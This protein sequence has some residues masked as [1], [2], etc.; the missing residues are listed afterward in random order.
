MVYQLLL[1]LIIFAIDIRMFGTQSCSLKLR[2]D[3]I[4]T[5]TKKRKLKQWKVPIKTVQKA[6]S[7][8]IFLGPCIGENDERKA[9][10]Q[11]NA[12]AKPKLLTML[13]KYGEVSWLVM[14][15]EVTDTTHGKTY[16]FEGF[17]PQEVDS[18]TGS[19][20]FQ[21]DLVKCNDINKCGSEYVTVTIMAT[22]AVATRNEEGFLMIPNLA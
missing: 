3:E 13:N 10:I 14:E 9:Y 5:L 16:G 17:Y 20:D 11:V 19:C 2:R 22:V 6:I 18:M 8:D 4:L 7:I 1:R 21:Q 15:T 12:M